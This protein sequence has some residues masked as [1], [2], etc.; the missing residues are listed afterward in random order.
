MGDIFNKHLRDK[1]DGFGG[2]LR[3]EHVMNHGPLSRWNTRASMG[4]GR[5]QRLR[6]GGWG[7]KPCLLVSLALFTAQIW[8][9]LSTEETFL[10]PAEHI[11]FSGRKDLM[12]QV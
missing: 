11:W 5:R 8:I 1:T 2:L 9:L 6:G 3:P 7:D 4:I 12:C 10:S